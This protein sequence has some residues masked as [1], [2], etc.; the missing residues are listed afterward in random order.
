MTFTSAKA[1]ERNRV[2]RRRGASDN[3]GNRLRPRARPPSFEESRFFRQVTYAFVAGWVSAR[4]P[5]RLDSRCRFL[6]RGPS[7][8]RL[9]VFAPRQAYVPIPGPLS[10]HESRSVRLARTARYEPQERSSRRSRPAAASANRASASV[11]PTRPR[12]R[13]ESSEARRPPMLSRRSPRYEA[14]NRPT[15]RVTA[16][17]CP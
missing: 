9:D 6:G 16:S 15:M 13:H 12:R 3:A 10:R 2:S 8:D 4:L 5:D 7:N 1:H 11:W 14:K 17:S